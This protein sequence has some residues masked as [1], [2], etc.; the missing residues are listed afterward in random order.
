[1]DCYGSVGLGEGVDWS[2]AH[3]SDV[4]QARAAREQTLGFVRS[5]GLAVG[6]E[7]GNDY[8]LPWLDWVEGPMTL[9]R[10]SGLEVG[11]GPKTPGRDYAVSIS[12]KYR[13]PFYSLVH[14]DEVVITWRWED[15]LGAVPA[16]DR[17]KELW[18]VLYGNP[19]LY[20]MDRTTWTAR[21]AEIQRREH[22][23][24]PWLRHVAGRCM[25]SHRFL[26]ADHF[27]Q[28][29]TFDDGSTAVVNFGSQSYEL[30]DGRTVPAQGYLTRLGR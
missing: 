28:E 9:V 6:T 3:P 1:M 19:P 10:W 8:L 21:R 22:G 24:G 2:P 29:A 12:P 11:D 14:H 30:G 17:D 23:L 4:F 16:F 20:F 5:M 26:T 27:V 7:C 25:R 15:G 18:C 13:I